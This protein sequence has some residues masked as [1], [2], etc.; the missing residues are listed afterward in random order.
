VE[1]G[2]GNELHLLLDWPGRD[3]RVMITCIAYRLRI[4][5]PNIEYKIS[6]PYFIYYK[7]RLSL[8]TILVVLATWWAKKVAEVQITVSMQPFKI[9]GNGFLEYIDTRWFELLQLFWPTFSYS[10]PTRPRMTTYTVQ[11]SILLL[12]ERKVVQSS[13]QR[14]AK[15]ALCKNR[16]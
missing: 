3:L 15:T 14:Q 5:W 6:A 7:S 1:S 12:P 16:C 13:G 9:T 4:S 2:A 10:E 11:N 8:V